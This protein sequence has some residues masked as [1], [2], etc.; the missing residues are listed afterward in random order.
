MGI[1]NKSS[2]KILPPEPI[3][4]V[5]LDSISSPQLT[6]WKGND[7]F[8]TQNVE[9]SGNY[10]LIKSSSGQIYQISKN[11]LNFRQVN[12]VEE[13]KQQILKLKEKFKSMINETGKALKMK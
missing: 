7:S 3:G 6:S 4:F 5:R 2:I 11:G 13:E 9:V 10:P 8:F 12:I 1:E